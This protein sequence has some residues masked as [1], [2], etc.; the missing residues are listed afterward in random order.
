MKIPEQIKDLLYFT[1]SERNGISLLLVLLLLAILAPYLYEITIPQTDNDL[2][3]FKKEIAEFE[4]HLKETKK[5]S[6]KNRLDK[7][8]ENRYDTLDLFY[9]DPNRTSDQSFTK[10]GLTDK[11]IATI[12][13]YLNKGGHFYV[14]DD[15]R[16]IYGIR[17]YQ[18]L[19]LKPFILLAEKINNKKKPDNY[20]QDKTVDTLFYFDPNTTSEKDFARL[21]LKDRQIKTIKNYLNKGGSFQKKEDFKKIYGIDKEQ[22][23]RLEAFIKIKK[24]PPPVIS[25]IRYTELNS[26]SY[27]DL[28]KI[29]GIGDYLANNIINYRNRLGGYINKKQLLEIKNFRESTFKKISAQITVDISN[30]T[31]ININFADME[32]MAHHPYLSYKQSKAIEKYR[33]QNGSYKTIDVLL[34]Q[35]IIS[36]STFNKIKPYI[37]VK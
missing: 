24:T 26:A 29:N 3:T 6:Y 9:F 16:K 2:S 1:K 14:K 18:Y 33:T 28:I 25:D 17:N 35:K 12:N 21:G 20:K 36:N 7:Y 23:N 34:N 10:L 31:K 30:I 15:F 5:Q 37:V 19:K 32:E 4:N 13:N 8:I 27:S 22:Y 11:Q